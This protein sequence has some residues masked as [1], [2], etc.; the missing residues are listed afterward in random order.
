MDSFSG[1]WRIGGEGVDEEVKAM[2]VELLR[3]RPTLR[4]P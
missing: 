4:F 3:G 2:D 1:A